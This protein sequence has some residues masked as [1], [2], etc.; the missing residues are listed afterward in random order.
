[1]ASTL[2][3]LATVAYLVSV[4][5]SMTAGVLYFR[6]P[7]ATLI[8]FGFARYFYGELRRTRPLIFVG[9]LGGVVLGFALLVAANSVR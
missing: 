3:L 5:C 2:R 9:S 1:M 7:Q 4:A 6:Q 8:G